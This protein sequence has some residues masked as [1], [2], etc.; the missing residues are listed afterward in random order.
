MRESSVTWGKD[1]GLVGG[2]W[3]S[4]ASRM[5]WGKGGDFLLHLHVVI[6]QL[7][8]NHVGL[9]RK[10]TRTGSKRIVNERAILSS[11]VGIEPVHRG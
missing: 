8:C 7:F 11:L 6:L 5:T 1:D 4:A 2:L 9:K 10:I 3:V